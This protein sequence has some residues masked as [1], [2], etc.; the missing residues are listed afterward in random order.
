MKWMSHFYF[1]LPPFLITVPLGL[2]LVISKQTSRKV[3]KVYCNFTEQT[4]E[5]TL[6]TF[7]KQTA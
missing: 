7:A 1:I 4:R 5:S 6:G 3:V 2:H